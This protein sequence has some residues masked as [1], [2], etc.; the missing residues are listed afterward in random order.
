MRVAVGFEH[1]GRVKSFLAN[2]GVVGVV[3]GNSQQDDEEINVK[4]F[5]TW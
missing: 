5:V 4:Y 1:L 3:R 2:T